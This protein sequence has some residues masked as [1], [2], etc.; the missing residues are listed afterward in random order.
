MGAALIDS[1]P[2]L[3]LVRLLSFAVA[4]P[5]FAGP[6]SPR[7][8]RLFVTL[9]LALVVVPAAR[10]AGSGGAH[11]LGIVFAAPLEI[12]LGLAL[13]YAF[14]LPFHALT[15]A[16]DFLGQEM[17]LNTASQLD[18]VTGRPSPLLSRLFE[19][20]GMV[21]FVELGGF[22]LLLKT[23]SA[24]FELAPP[25][26]IF[27]PTAWIEPIVGGSSAAVSHGIGTAFPVAALLLLL[28][29]FAAISAR[30]LPRLHLFDFAWA[31]RIM[32]ALVLVALLLPRLGPR[33]LGFT[34][35]VATSVGTALEAR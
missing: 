25:G 35:E 7:H 14:S 32:A 17:G 4:F 27:S 31:V 2:I 28:T 1:I 5:I 10:G 11:G 22:A 30:V 26:A 6:G 18:P 13:G 8:V 20:L 16:G 12:A 15:V 23:L 19:I 34:E 29:F 24:T 3:A 9:G 33:L 21:V